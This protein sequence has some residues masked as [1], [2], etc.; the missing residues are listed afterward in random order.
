MTGSDGDKGRSSVIDFSSPY[1]LHP[2]DSPK[3]PSVNEV[4]TDGNYN[5]WARE[6]KNFLFAKNKID[7]V[8]GTLKKPETSSSEYK[9]WMRCDAMIKGW[10][11]TAMEKGIRDSVKYS[12][13]SS[14]IWSDL[15]ERFRKESAPRAYELKKKITVTRQEVGYPDWWLGKKDDKEKPK[16]AYVETGTSLIPRL[17]EGQYQEFVKFCSHSSNNVEAKHEAN[18]AANKDDVWVVDSGCTKYI[19]H[20]S[21][22]LENKK[23][24]SNEAPVVIPNGH[25]IPVEGKG[26]FI[27]PGGAKINGVLYIPNFKLN[28]IYTRKDRGTR[29]G[30]HS[31]SSSFAFDQPISSHLNNDDD[32]NG[33][34]TLRTS[35]LS[36]IC[37]VNSLINNVPQVFQN[38]PNIDPHMEPFYTRQTEIIN[39]QVQI[40]DE[41]RDRLRSIKK[42]LRNLWKNMKK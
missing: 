19:T 27:L 29:R 13:T 11:T 10:L 38:P 14:E 20:K 25:V 7:F 33:K 35:T 1:Y 22:L 17:N 41:H 4:L 37:F 21:N 23:D 2:S 34:G 36:P 39:R 3:Q 12:N 8:D 6:M 9:S 24:T 16:A 32:G 30:R 5:D 15:K 26:D 28:L 31:T 40:R 42:G 18:M